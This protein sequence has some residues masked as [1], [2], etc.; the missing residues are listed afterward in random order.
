MMNANVEWLRLLRAVL[1]YGKP[2]CP[3]NPAGSTHELLGDLTALRMT[4]PVVTVVFRKMGFRFLAAESAWILSGDNRLSTIAPFANRIGV[5]SDDQ[6]TF[7]GAYGPKFVDQVGWVAGEL[8]RDPHSRRAVSIVWRER[9]GPTLDAPC[10]VALQW[11]MRD[12]QLHC[13]ATMRSSDAW[14][15][16]VYD[17]HTFSMLSAYLLLYLRNLSA[18]WNNVGLGNLR[19]TAG[20]Q[21]VYDRD[22]ETALACLAYPDSQCY[23]PFD[24]NEF[25]HPDD[26]TKHLWAVARREPTERSWL[27]DLIAR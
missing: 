6:L 2:V 19:L 18:F 25:S 8:A 9:P 5:T 23:R 27:T 12:D 26:L 11:L 13:V 7:R 16:W 22:R 17:V 4:S 1:T 14:L 20:S 3:D 21:H 15:G 10:T 24:V